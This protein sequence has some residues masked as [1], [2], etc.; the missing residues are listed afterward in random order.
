MT[1]AGH[2]CA[3]ASPAGHARRIEPVP[4]APSAAATT[5]GESAA[6]NGVRVSWHGVPGAVARA[7]PRH[8]S[9]THRSCSI[10]TRHLTRLLG[11][12]ASFAIHLHDPQRSCE[13]EW[14]GNLIIPHRNRQRRAHGSCSRCFLRC[15]I[16]VPSCRKPASRSF[17]LPSLRMIVVGILLTLSLSFDVHGIRSFRH[18]QLSQA[19]CQT[20]GCACSVGG[21]RPRAS[22]LR[23]RVVLWMPRALAVSVRF[24][25]C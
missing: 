4:A 2:S 24:Q 9:C 20:P 18:I 23:K 13:V 11:L 22:I 5:A 25:L 16:N 17:S 6:W 10:T 8:R 1:T 3:G 21:V 19:A 7:T 14:R 15:L 12:P